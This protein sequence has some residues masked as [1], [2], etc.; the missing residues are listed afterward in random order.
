[1]TL[2]GGCVKPNN[3]LKISRLTL[4]IMEVTIGHIYSN[5]HH[6]YKSGNFGQ[7]EGSKRQKC[8]EHYQQQPHAFAGSFDHAKG[9]SKFRFDAV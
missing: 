5:V 7:M 4:S 1:M 8:L 2:P 9:V 3:Q 6:G